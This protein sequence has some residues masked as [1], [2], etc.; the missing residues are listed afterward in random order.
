MDQ[1]LDDFMALEDQR[2]Y[3]DGGPEHCAG[4]GKDRP[5]EDMAD[6]GAQCLWCKTVWPNV[7]WLRD[8]R[9]C[10]DCGRR[11]GHVWAPHRRRW[12]CAAC[13]CAWM[14][15]EKRAEIEETVA[16]LTN[17]DVYGR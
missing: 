5:I 17:V 12:Q 14:T 9:F 8:L 15:E 7:N 13:G 6:D 4:C 10:A 3:D 11:W 1:A 16:G 2:A